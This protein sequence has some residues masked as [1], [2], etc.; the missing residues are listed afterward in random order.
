M[1]IDNMPLNSKIAKLFKEKL[2]ASWGSVRDQFDTP[3]NYYLSRILYESLYAPT[4]IAD[5]EITERIGFD[6]RTILTQ[7]IKLP[8]RNIPSLEEFMSVV[9]RALTSDID[10]SKNLY[11][12]AIP[13][14]EQMAQYGPIRIW[15][16]GDVYGINDQL[17]SAE[18]IKKVATAGLGKLRNRI[19]LQSGKNRKDILTLKAAENKLP[20]I[21]EILGEFKN[22]KI[23]IAILLD[24]QISNIIDAIE[25][26]KCIQNIHIYPI[27]IHNKNEDE[28]E[29]EYEKIK[30]IKQ[31]TKIKDVLPVINTILQQNKVGF[32]VDFDGV[33]VDDKKRIKAQFET[34][35]NKL[36]EKK[37]L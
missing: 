4:T 37:W 10:Y 27:W 9:V 31:V 21:K 26:S 35:Y 7:D 25:E 15:T 13:T 8:K 6:R 3:N 24:D 22:Q 1:K 36:K 19:A 17:G 18:Q 2:F 5:D 20:F 12:D 32:I 23:E 30:N 33:L 34:V 29:L 28:N 11:P 16:K 14:I